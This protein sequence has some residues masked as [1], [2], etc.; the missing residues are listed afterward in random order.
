MEIN[1]ISAAGVMVVSPFM[2]LYSSGFHSEWKRYRAWQEESQCP[3]I[4]LFSWV[5]SDYSASLLKKKEKSMWLELLFSMS[6]YRVVTAGHRGD[7][8]VRP[9]RLAVPS[10][11]PCHVQVCLSQNVSVAEGQRLNGEKL[12]PTEHSDLVTHKLSYVMHMP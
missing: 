7:R 12:L 4:V 10:M 1:N 2:K 9:R 11:A 5:D 8:D 3:S 6:I